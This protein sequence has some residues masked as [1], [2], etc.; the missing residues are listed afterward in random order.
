MTRTSFSTRGPWKILVVD[1]VLATGG[2]AAA[3][4][5][6]VRHL[7]GELV[8]LAFLP[9]VSVVAAL[10]FAG[11][12]IGSIMPAR[13]LAVRANETTAVHLA[14]ASERAALTDTIRRERDQIAR[15]QRL[16]AAIAGAASG[17]E[18]SKV[19]D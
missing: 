8:G 3:A 5:E 1:D 16:T 19:D 15:L 9:F 13:D 14:L 18:G 17:D 6:L 11:F 12:M 2:T 7:G 10:F 4:V